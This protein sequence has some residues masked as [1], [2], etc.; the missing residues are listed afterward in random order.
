LPPT[1]E[2]ERLV[3]R[4]MTLDYL[5]DYLALRSDPEIAR[6]LRPR[7]RPALHERAKAD[8]DS[9]DRH[10][11]GPF[12]ALDRGTGNFCG[13]INL[14]DRCDAD[15]IE[16]GWMIKPEAWGQGLA[17]EAVRAV[18]GWCF[19]VLDISHVA[20]F[21]K[22]A[23]ES[24]HRLAGRLGMTLRRIEAS[25]HG[26]EQVWAISRDTWRRSNSRGQL[27]RE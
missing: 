10:G 17:T 25:D 24:S 21:I 2:T 11:Y 15:E 26:A 22:P 12:A 5:D 18:I 4:P 9:W 16:I 6:Y 14:Q 1:I 27:G 13:R 8:Q 19:Q 7:D 20:A 23:N 3:L